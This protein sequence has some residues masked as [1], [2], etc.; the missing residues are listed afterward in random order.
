[1]DCEFIDECRNRENAIKCGKCETKSKMLLLENPDNFEKIE[2]DDNAGGS[3]K[4]SSKKFYIFH[5]NYD[6]L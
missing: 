3:Y 1:M 6:P 5:D 4:P 2:K